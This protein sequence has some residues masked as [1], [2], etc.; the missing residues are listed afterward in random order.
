[1]AS[2]I[3]TVLNPSVVTKIVSTIRA[4]GSILAKFFGFEI[5]GKNV[6]S[7]QGRTYTYDIYDNVRDVAR[8]R[9]PGSASGSISLNPVGNV[10]ITLAKSAEKVILDYN[11]LL[12]IRT[13][14]ANAGTRD[15]MG[16][17]YVDM[18]LKTL[19][20]RQDNFREFV[21]AGALCNGGTY[22]FFQ[23]GDDLVPT[24]D[25]TGTFISVDHKIPAS[26]LLVGSSFAA[27]LTLDSGGNIVT[28]PWS[29]ASTDIVG[30]L[31]EMEAAMD[32]QVGQPLR[33]FICGNRVWKNVITNNSIRNIA[34]S[35]NTP[36]ATYENLGFKNP[37]GTDAGVFRAVLKGLPQF[38]WI[39]VNS[40][41][42]LATGSATNL[43]TQ[44][45]M[46]DDY[47][48]GMIEPDGSWFQMVEGSEIVKDNDLAPATEREGFYA[49]LMEKADPARFEAHGLQNVGLEI[50]VPKGIFNARVQ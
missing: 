35:S 8:G 25:T 48:T 36:Y 44:R 40:K 4:P 24:L 6:Q 18:Q 34:G 46:P 28:A 19:R 32:G 17:R 27:G 10:S 21:T 20:Q 15:V 3:L 1:M 49:W 31:L 42:R 12:Q 29:N 43:T 14:G 16:R 11:K 22:G 5:G 50:N 47:V 33:K 7:I 39:L 30:Q 41:I 23:N 9:M 26:N 2:D 37:D 45:V 13:L 38:E